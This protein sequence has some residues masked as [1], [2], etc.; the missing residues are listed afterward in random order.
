VPAAV[1]AVDMRDLMT[2]AFP[3]VLGIAIPDAL[4]LHAL[5]DAGAKTHRVLRSLDPA[6]AVLADLLVLIEALSTANLIGIALV[7]TASVIAVSTRPAV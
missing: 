5:R 7:I 3:G 4:F 2:I 6:V 1:D